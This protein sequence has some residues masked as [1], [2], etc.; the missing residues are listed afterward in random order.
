MKTL[1]VVGALILMVS[2]AMALAGVYEVSQITA[3]LV[4]CCFGI[5]ELAGALR[6]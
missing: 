4:L 6:F 5:N 3:G 1:C 2:G